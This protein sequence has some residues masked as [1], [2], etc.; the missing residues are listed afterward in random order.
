[1]ETVKFIRFRLGTDVKKGRNRSKELLHPL[2]VKNENLQLIQVGTCK[3][4]TVVRLSQ[5][6]VKESRALKELTSVTSSED[7]EGEKRDLR[8]QNM[9][10]RP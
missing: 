8:D 4:K 2:C 6:M 5:N 10:V 3:R 9:V 7:I 1:M